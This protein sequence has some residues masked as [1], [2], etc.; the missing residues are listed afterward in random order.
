M[1]GERE[2]H[3]EIWRLR[4]RLEYIEKLK[5]ATNTSVFS[6]LLR[7]DDHVTKIRAMLSDEYAKSANIKSN[8]NRLSVQEGLKAI[9]EYLKTYRF[10]PKH[11][12]ACYYGSV[13]ADPCSDKESRFKLYFQ[14]P[15]VI[16]R[17]VYNCDT[18]FETQTLR[19]LLQ[20]DTAIG[21]IVID[22]KGALFATV[23]GNA[24]EIHQKISVDLPRKHT[25]GGQSASRFARIRQ[26]A[27]KTY[28]SKVCE[29][30][31]E[32]FIADNVPNIT[33]IVLAGQAHLKDYLEKSSRFDIRLKPIIYLVLT[34]DYGGEA[35]LNEAI[36]MSSMEIN[37]IRLGREMKL[38]S[39]F[40]EHLKRGT[41]NFVAYGI[42]D[43]MEA[44]EEGA[45][46]TLIVWQDLALMRWHLKNPDSTSAVVYL[47]PEEQPKN[48]AIAQ[49]IEKVLLVDWLADNVSSFGSKLELVS[50]QSSDGTMLVQG[51]DGLVA[52][53]RYSRIATEV[54][55]GQQDIDADDENLLEGV[56]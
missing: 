6:I 41:E 54:D 2:D 9:C 27:R 43:V 15:K 29:K 12:L 3:S 47:A 44:L 36:R 24:K 55:E 50:D 13:L 32:V 48:L 17:F 46:D 40:M 22:G 31:T 14:P 35:G 53:L 5:P 8:Q 34:V 49:E 30:A 4:R 33:N 45:V 10:F 28:V 1:P 11:G 20:D 18:S 37:N 19:T 42:N 7:P 26:D 21:F 23:R 16:P 25:R 39:T 52:L 51:F 56:Y 38:I